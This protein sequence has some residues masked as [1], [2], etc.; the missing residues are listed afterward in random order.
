M[1]RSLMDISDG[2]GRA[3]ELHDITIVCL[4][5]MYIWLPAP[6]GCLLQPEVR[7][8]RKAGGLDPQE[9]HP[10]IKGLSLLCDDI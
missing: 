10:V 5:D 2:M 9:S 6:F 7:G 1:S 8:E 4:Y 3:D